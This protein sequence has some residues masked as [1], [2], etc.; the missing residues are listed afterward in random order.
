[1]G[2]SANHVAT[3]VTGYV[4]G[5]LTWGFVFLFDFISAKWKTLNVTRRAGR[6]RLIAVI[7][8]MVVVTS[9]AVLQALS[10][11][12]KERMTAVIAVVLAIY[13]IART[14]WGLLQLEQYVKWCGYTLQ[15][16]RATN[17]THRDEEWK[18]NRDAAEADADDDN[19]DLGEALMVNEDIVDN[20]FSGHDIS[21]YVI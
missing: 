1:M 6:V 17:P 16:I 9:Y 11:G 20:E 14:L 21:V 2:V 8:P 10:G 15:C 12:Y 19:V 5:F 4:C 3:V 7:V 13:H 18:S